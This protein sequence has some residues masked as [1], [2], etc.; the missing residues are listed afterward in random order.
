MPGYFG[1]SSDSLASAL[2]AFLTELSARDPDRSSRSSLLQMRT[3][4][5]VERKWDFTYRGEKFFLTTFAPCYNPGSGRST[6]GVDKTFIMMQPHHSFDRALPRDLEKR[7]EVHKLI[8]E[9][10]ARDGKEYQE[11][12]GGQPLSNAAKYIK[13]NANEL[14]LWWT[15]EPK[16][17]TPRGPN[18]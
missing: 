2:H 3:T 6:C 1:K 9:A 8:K 10:F 7:K 16:W 15:V 17:P 5:Q 18:E 11:E 4:G 13:A 12:H 14:I